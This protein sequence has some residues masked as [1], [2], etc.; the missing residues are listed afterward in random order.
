MST[1]VE[2]EAQLVARGCVPG[3]AMISYWYLT[4]AHQLLE[5]VAVNAAFIP[6]VLYLGRAPW[7]V[8]VPA[9]SGGGAGGVA[10]ALLDAVLSL[11]TVVCSVFTVYY[12]LQPDCAGRIRL[13]YILQPCH[14]S[15][16]MLVVLAACLAAGRGAAASPLFEA[17]LCTVF[18]AIFA[19]ATP[20]FRG[21]YLP[22]EVE[23]FIVQHL[24]LL[25]LP[26]VWIARRRFHC[27]HDWRPWVFSWAAM[28][29]AHW[30]VFQP[31]SWLSAHN[32]NYMMVPP[33]IPLLATKAYRLVMIGVCLI[34][35][36]VVRRAFA[37]VAYL[38]GVWGGEGSAQGDAGAGAGTGAAASSGGAGAMPRQPN[39]G[40]AGGGA[41]VKRR[42]TVKASSAHN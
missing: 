23:H 17:Y 27:Y 28:T 41:T 7:R 15:N 31:A 21:L 5:T 18:G 12:K 26:C 42:V 13:A 8:G 4:P 32:V 2:A 34:V 29:L 40:A 19:L 3:E 20:D 35:S 24:L 16:L 11:T 10:L 38:V 39:E 25:A 22:L 1:R 6:L 37:A 14:L 33:E 30:D 36:W 9:A